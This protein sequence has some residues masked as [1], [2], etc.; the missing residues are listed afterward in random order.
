MDEGGERTVEVRGWWMEEWRGQYWMEERGH[1]VGEEREQW[2]EG[3]GEGGQ[4]M[5]LPQQ[6]RDCKGKLHSHFQCRSFVAVERVFG[7]VSGVF[8]WH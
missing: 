5:I 3:E 6:T 7:W 2:M 1:W 4:H 8:R